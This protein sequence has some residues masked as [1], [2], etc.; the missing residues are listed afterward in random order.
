MKV[1]DLTQKD[2]TTTGFTIETLNVIDSGD[3]KQIVASASSPDA[4][5]TNTESE[6]VAD[7]ATQ[8]VFGSLQAGCSY[9]VTFQT[10][11]GG[12]DSDSAPSATFCTREFRI[13]YSKLQ[14]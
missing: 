2:H 9:D 6:T 5:C 3:W 8:I 10:S 13:V 1:A 14:I 11:C 7:P 4:A 12:I